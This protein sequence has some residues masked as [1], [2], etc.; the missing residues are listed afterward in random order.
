MPY[1]AFDLDAMDAAPNVARAAGITEDAVIAGLARMWRHCWQ[2]KTNVVDATALRGFFGGE[3]TAALGSFGFLE[4][5]DGQHRV[6]GADRYLRLHLGQVAGGHAAKKHL[7][8]GA[9]QKAKASR[10][11]AERGCR[12][13]SPDSAE[14]S[15]EI[16]P[17]ELLG[18]LSALSSSIEHRASKEASTSAAVVL[19]P[20]KAPHP[21][22]TVSVPEALK[23]WQ[24]FEAARAERFGGVPMPYP[25]ATFESRWPAFLA[26]HGGDRGWAME[27]YIRA[28]ADP[29]LSKRRPAGSL[30]AFLSPIQW[31]KFVEAK[32]QSEPAHPCVDCGK[33]ATCTAWDDWVCY[34]CLGARQ[35]KELASAELA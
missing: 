12:E 13:E 27:T 17:R 4:A 2:R 31:P 3:V 26:A 16:E 14:T 24:A 21:P 9:R 18:S 7:I 6:K 11:A 10:E 1:L 19:W 23:D 28:W 22:P 34:P 32:A 5:W 35:A 29:W 33:P 20:A 25:P 15:A 8:P 30:E